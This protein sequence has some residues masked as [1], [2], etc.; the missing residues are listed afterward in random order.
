MH[1]T[2]QVMYL[3]F[4]IHVLYRSGETGSVVLYFNPLVFISLIRR[5]LA[6]M[7]EKMDVEEA[8]YEARVRLEAEFVRELRRS[9]IAIHQEQ[10]NEQHYESFWRILLNQFCTVSTI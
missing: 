6:E 10:A 1:C 7:L 3:S 4:C 2:N 8:D 9:P 5:G